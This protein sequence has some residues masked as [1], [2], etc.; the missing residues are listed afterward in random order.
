MQE[1]LVGEEN[2]AWNTATIQT[3][4]MELVA[5]GRFVP[6]ASP[7]AVDLMRYCSVGL[8][9][10]LDAAAAVGVQ[11]SDLTQVEW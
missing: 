5:V 9:T 7:S 8:A 6:P 1:S 10:H 2:K 11:H 4:V 3:Q